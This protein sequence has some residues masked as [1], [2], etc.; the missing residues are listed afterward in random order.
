MDCLIQKLK[1]NKPKSNFSNNLELKNLELTISNSN[2]D[3]LTLNNTEKIWEFYWSSDGRKNTHRSFSCLEMHDRDH[4]FFQNATE[5]VMF[6]RIEDN[7]WLC[8]SS[9]NL[10]DELTKCNNEI[11]RK[12]MQ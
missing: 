7:E 2:N 10:I 11:N 3:R 8:T 1:H 4:Y 6:K 12:I 9:D 5:S